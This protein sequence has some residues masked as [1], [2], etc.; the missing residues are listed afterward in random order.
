MNEIILQIENGS[1]GEDAIFNQG[2]KMLNSNSSIT[3][4]AA[5]NDLSD[6]VINQE[7]EAVDDTA[8]IIDQ[9]ACVGVTDPELCPEEPWRSRLL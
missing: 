7:A 2:S 1:E 5:L 8:G 9:I 3:F 6:T 4:Q